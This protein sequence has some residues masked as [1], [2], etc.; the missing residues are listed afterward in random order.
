MDMSTLLYLKWMSN[1][2]LL[3]SAGNSAQCYVAAG[4]GGEFGGECIHVYVWLS[5]LAVNQLLTLLTGYTSVQNRKL[6]KKGLCLALVHT[7]ITRL[8]CR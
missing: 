8:S 5:P 4:M 1:K 7:D 3:Y 6:I 2:G